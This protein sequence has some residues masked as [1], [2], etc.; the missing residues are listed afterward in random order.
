V[1]ALKSLA[2]ELANGIF[3]SINYFRAASTFAGIAAYKFLIISISKAMVLS[4]VVKI[5]PKV[6]QN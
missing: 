1:C 2:L 6:S 5:G 3:I 4:F